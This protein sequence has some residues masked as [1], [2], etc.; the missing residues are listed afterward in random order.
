MRFSVFASI[1]ATLAVAVSAKPLR[2]S[3][4]HVV[5]ERRLA[6]HS[7]WTRASRPHRSSVLPVRIGLTQENLHRAEEF[8]GDVSNPDSPNYGRHW[9]KEKVI[10]TFA[11]KKETIDDVMEWLE[12]EGIAPAR[13]RLSNARN[14]LFFNATV[15]EVERL[16][17]TE[18]HIYRHFQHGASHVACEQYHVPEHLLGHIDMVTPTVHF[19]HRVGHE[20]GRKPKVDLPEEAQTEL[21]KRTLSKRQRPEKGI[22]GGPT[23]GSL[24]KQGAT[25]TNALMD[26]NQCDTMITVDCLRALY[27]TPPGALAS[28]N[29]SLGIVEYTPQAILQSDLN[30][31]FSQFQTQLNGKGPTVKLIDNAEYA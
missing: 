27:N 15:R 24:A 14:W 31:F 6:T 3:S 28:A 18:Y 26:L 11:P 21:R 30:L 1:L 19:D 13:V 2:R 22:L 8:L 10:E 25:I 5:H 29:N 7:S 20:R 4:K 23:D 9:S 17:K 16:L 12:T